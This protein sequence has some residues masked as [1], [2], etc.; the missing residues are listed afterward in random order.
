VKISLLQTSPSIAMAIEFING[1]EQEI[2]G[3]VI[4]K[5]GA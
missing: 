4:K 5:I 3:Q 1:F 2:E